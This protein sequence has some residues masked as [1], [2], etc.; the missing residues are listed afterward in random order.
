M[1]MLQ[2]VHVW[3]LDGVHGGEHNGVIDRYPSSHVSAQYV[4]FTQ[5]AATVRHSCHIKGGG[6]EGMRSLTACCRIQVHEN[7]K[8]WTWQPKGAVI[9][10]NL[11]LWGLEGRR[12]C[13]V[14]DAQKN[15][16]QNYDGRFRKGRVDLVFGVA[17]VPPLL[18]SFHHLL[19]AETIVV[20]GCCNPRPFLHCSHIKLW[21]GRL[22]TCTCQDVPFFR[23]YVL[24]FQGCKGGVGGLQP[25]N[26]ARG[27][28]I[29]Q[30]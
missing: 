4:L 10:N 20:L 25:K 30:R 21:W 11:S 13:G 15:K 23:L 26:P 2:G 16:K 9:H 22:L 5:A 27:K 7:I 28:Q 8:K 19:P 18:T 29:G 1:G 3:V 6:R 24:L 17:I 12:N 14:G